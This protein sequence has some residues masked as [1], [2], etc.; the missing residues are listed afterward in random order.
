MQHEEGQP[1]VSGITARDH[2]SGGVE[3][4]GGARG[5]GVRS[6]GRV[7]VGVCVGVGVCICEQ[8]LCVRVCGVFAWS[9]HQFL[10]AAVMQD[11]TLG[12]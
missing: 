12:A 3:V 7:C 6:G 4:P 9:L 8:C 11:H 1:G 2:E 5:E 10:G